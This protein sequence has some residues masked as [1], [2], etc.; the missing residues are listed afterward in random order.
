MT[1]PIFLECTIVKAELTSES[2]EF[3]IEILIGNHFKIKRNGE[4]SVQLNKS[5]L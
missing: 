4:M 2:L 5:N 3:V 1:V